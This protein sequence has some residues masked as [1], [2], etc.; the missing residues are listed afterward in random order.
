MG[1]EFEIQGIDPELLPDYKEYQNY[2]KQP[3]FKTHNPISYEDWIKQKTKDPGSI[4]ATEGEPSIDKTLNEK[5]KNYQ[6]WWK[7]SGQRRQASMENETHPYIGIKKT[8][9]PSVEGALMLTGIGSIPKLLTMPAKT[10]WS[11]I[12]ETIV[13]GAYGTA[14]YYADKAIGGDGSVGRTMGGLFGL[15]ET[16]RLFDR[17]R[18]AFYRHITPFGYGNSVSNTPKSQEIKN[19]LKETFL[20]LGRQD[21][22]GPAPWMRNVNSGLLEGQFRNSSATNIRLRDQ[23]V[24]KAMKL[25]PRRTEPQIY[26]ENPDGTYSYDVEAIN[27]IKNQTGGATINGNFSSNDLQLKSGAYGDYFTGNGG[28]VGVTRDGTGTYMED[29]WDL[30]PF[31]DE[32]RSLWTWGTKHIPGLKNFEGIQFL[33]GN[34]FKVKH[35]LND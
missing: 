11:V 19:T 24:R 12:P 34:P 4:I 35:K 2:L 30:Q 29:V 20:S 7:G 23:A 8:I 27:K 33:R 31:Q 25:D 5:A 6:H 15:K 32:Y 3:Y 17:G 9:V 16:L 10:L 18:K 13:G 22:D 28:Y 21:V 1:E 26:V 14:G